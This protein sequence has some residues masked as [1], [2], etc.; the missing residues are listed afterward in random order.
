MLLLALFTASADVPA[1]AIQTLSAEASWHGPRVFEGGERTPRREAWE[2]LRDEAKDA[3]LRA[4]LLAHPAPGVRYGALRALEDR[5]DLHR[6]PQRLLKDRAAV[7]ACEGCDCLETSVG[8]RL[9]A[10]LA[11]RI[12]EED[13]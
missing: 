11:G 1:A 10:L 6:L 9:E 12:P 8:M 2:Q 7:E 13:R 3:E 5:V 4:L